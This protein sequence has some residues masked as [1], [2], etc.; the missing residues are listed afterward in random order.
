[1]KNKIS[2]DFSASL[3]S[4]FREPSQTELALVALSEATQLLEELELR[5]M[6]EIT[7]RVMESASRRQG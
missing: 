6:A 1:M 2:Q 5:K 4:Q 3:F 7:T